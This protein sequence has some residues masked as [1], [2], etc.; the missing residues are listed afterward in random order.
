MTNLH[1]DHDDKLVAL[2]RYHPVK[3]PLKSREAGRDIY[4]D[5]EV[6]EIR[7][8]GSRDTGVYPATSISHTA[9]DGMFSTEGIPVTYAERFSKQYRQFKEQQAQTVSGTPLTHAKF[10]TPGKCAE[11]KAMNIYTVEMLAAIDGQELKNLGNGG[12]DLKNAA[13]EYIETSKRNAIPAAM[14]EELEA[15][16]ARNAILEEDFKTLGLDPNLPPA[17]S[18]DPF[19]DMSDDQLRDYVQTQVGAKPRGDLT[20]KMLLQ[21]ARDATAKSPL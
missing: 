2:F 1:L 4:D 21:M 10:I 8:P 3:N 7:A 17:P 20:R 11:L 9:F 16:R 14:M 5:L 19:A 13:L 12:R 18:K 15:L 6:C